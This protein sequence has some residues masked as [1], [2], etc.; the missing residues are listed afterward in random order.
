[1]RNLVRTACFLLGVGAAHLAPAGAGLSQ[2]WP[3]WRGPDRDGV[4]HGVTVPAKWPKTL[5][6]EWQVSVG[7]GVAS[8]VVA[9]G[10]VYVFTRQKD[11]EVVRCFDLAGGKELWGSEPYPAPFKPGPGD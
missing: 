9:G 3:Q 2:D 10:R 4:V 1:M 7:E 6:Q 11:N 5:T 8:P